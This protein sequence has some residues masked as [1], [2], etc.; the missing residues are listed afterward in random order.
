MNLRRVEH[1]VVK[2]HNRLAES[3]KALREKVADYK[4]NSTSGP[5]AL[6]S[7]FGAHNGLLVVHNVGQSCCYCTMWAG[8][9]LPMNS[10]HL[11]VRRAFIGGP[12]ETPASAGLRAGSQ[13][14]WS[15]SC[16]SEP[17]LSGAITSPTQ[18]PVMSPKRCADMLTC[19]VE[20]SNATWM[21][22]IMAIFHKRC[23]ASGT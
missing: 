22:T 12:E 9:S 19:G 11:L 2:Q 1:E 3:K 14:P 13:S 21:A 15:G 8:W 7:L 20:R 18:N 4:L 5:I 10:T 17:P 16:R 6:S 23:F